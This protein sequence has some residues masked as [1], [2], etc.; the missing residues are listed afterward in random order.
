MSNEVAKK[1]RKQGKIKDWR[2]KQN[3]QVFWSRV[4]CLDRREWPKLV[5]FLETTMTNLYGIVYS[6]VLKGI[7][8]REISCAVLSKPQV[9]NLLLSLGKSPPLSQVYAIS[10]R[11]ILHT[12]ANNVS[13]TPIDP[14]SSNQKGFEVLNAATGCVKHI[15]GVQPA[16]PLPNDLPQRVLNNAIHLQITGDFPTANHR[17]LHRQHSSTSTS[18]PVFSNMH[19]S[20]KRGGGPTPARPFLTSNRPARLHA[21]LP[22]CCKSVREFW[23]LTHVPW[24]RACVGKEPVHRSWARVLA[25]VDKVPF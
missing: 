10:P 22:R 16:L 2:A 8:Q 24:R 25:L 18:P 11:S 7:V 6:R 14:A 20:M 1:R 13:C 21:L 17:N 15:V 4:D 9:V 3:E 23:T 5:P 19:Q 12:F